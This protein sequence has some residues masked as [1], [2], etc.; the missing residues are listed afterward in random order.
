[1]VI[2]TFCVVYPDIGA[3]EK[4]VNVEVAPP[5]RVCVTLLVPT[6]SYCTISK[7]SIS[8]SV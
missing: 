4:G 1:M 8:S 7:C 6:V 3:V 2:V 5:A